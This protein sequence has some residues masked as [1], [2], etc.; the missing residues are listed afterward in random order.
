VD[1]TYP[2]ACCGETNEVWLDPQAGRRQQLVE[3]CAVCCRPM[4]ITATWNP[5]AG[6]YDLDVYQ[7]DR[8]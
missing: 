5:V 6:A 3:D 1:Q 4:V 7:E 2:C 8:G